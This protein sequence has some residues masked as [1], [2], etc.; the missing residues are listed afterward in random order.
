VDSA[1]ELNLAA[2]NTLLK[3]IEEPPDEALVLL[4]SHTPGRLLATIRSRCRRLIMAPLDEGQVAE[5]LSRHRPGIDGE[6]AAVLARLA[7]GS[8][9]RALRLADSGALALYG[10]M[11]ALLA[12]APKIDGEALHR[13]AERLGRADAEPA[14]RTFMELFV[15]WLARLVRSGAAGTSP[16]E[17]VAG[18]DAVARGLLAG[19]GLEHW[20]EVWEKVGRL[21]VRADRANL[22]RKQV[23]ISAFTTL[24]AASRP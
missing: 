4:V 2:A 8:P 16:P 21:A 19:R 17:M 15:D 5:F 20:T 1:D 23:V 22:E 11:L 10:E 6:E 13:L 9:G 24:E 14:Y 12:Q 18:E 3:V 7:A